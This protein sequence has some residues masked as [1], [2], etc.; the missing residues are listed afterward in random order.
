MVQA[1]EPNQKSQSQNRISLNFWATHSFNIILMILKYNLESMSRRRR[2]IG[3]IFADL[4][5]FF[6]HYW[7]KVRHYERVLRSRL[8]TRGSESGTLKTNASSPMLSTGQP[9]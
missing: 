6:I 9:M 5:K 7:I 8:M 4:V 2:N 1:M 3:L